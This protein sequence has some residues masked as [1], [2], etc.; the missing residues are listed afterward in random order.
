[1]LQATGGVTYNWSGGSTPLNDTNSITQPGLYTVNMVDPNG[2]PVSQTITLTQNITPPTPGITNITGTTII[3]CNAPSIDLQATGGGTY[4]WN[5]NLGTTANVNITQAGTY[6]VVVTAANGCQDSSTVS[7]T[8][9]PVP[10]VTANDTTICSGQSVTLTPTY[11]PAGGQAVWTNGQL[12][13]GITV[14]PNTT[15]MY[16]VLYT[17]NGCT[18]TDDI[19]VTVNPTPTVS[20]NNP[21]ICFGDTTLLTATPNLPNGVYNWISANETTQSISVNP[22]VT[23]T[24]DVEYTLNGCTSAIATS[25][26]TVTPLPIIT[27]PNII[28]CEGATGTLTATANVG[29]GTYTWSQ[30]G[31]TAS[32]T[33]GPQAT[34]SYNVSYTVNG[35]TSNTESPTITVNPLPNVSFSADTTSGCVPVV[36]NLSADTTGQQA[37]YTWSSNGGGGSVGANAQMN[38]GVGGCYDV[39]LTATLNGCSYSVTQPDFVCVQDYPQASFEANPPSFTE[40]TQTL[41][42]NNTSIGATGYVWNFGDGNVSNQEYPEHLF[43]GTNDGYT[44]TLIASTSMGCMDSTSL[45]IDANLGAVYYIPNSFTPDGNQ[46]N[47]TFRP[48]FTTGISADEYEMLIFNRWGEI[49]FESKNI[50]EGWDGSYGVEGLD[51][52]SGTYTYKIV[53]T[54]LGVL[55]QKQII[56]GHVNLLR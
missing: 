12:T 8:V 37:S 2:C 7:I 21:N 26:V 52:P 35:C 18:A 16:S 47:Q 41:N 29:G 4:Q 25:T 55:E 6:T 44:I 46:F 45:F 28:I 33:E 11:Y 36:V 17:W 13:P 48:V 43:Q 32:I 1:V 31:T 42:F 34:T 54:P 38:F 53:C 51:C 39:T 9:A 5:N 10:A 40:S 30:G 3:D 19:T 56:T 24:Y 23:T 49:M 20:V 50:Y 22:Q 14:S 27:V 15:T